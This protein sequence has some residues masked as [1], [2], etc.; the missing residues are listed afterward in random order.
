MQTATQSLVFDHPAFE[1]HEQV[2][3]CSDATTNLRAIIAIHSTTIGPALGGTR[4]WAYEDNTSALE[5]VLRLSKA[6]TYKNAL[7][8]TGFGGGKAVIIGNPYRDK[9]V[10]LIQAY[11]T[12]VA[13]LGGHFV[14][15]EDVGISMRDADVMAEHCNYVHGTSRSRSG[16]PSIYTVQGVFSGIEAAVNHRLGRTDLKGIRVSVQGLGNVGM[17]LCQLLSKA[18]AKLTVSDIRM[19]AVRDA[20][21]Q[22]GAEAI[23]PEQVHSVEVD[24]FVPCA[25]G[26]I[27]NSR[28]IPEIQARV[29]AGSANN[30][31]ETEKDGELLQRRGILYAP[32]YV[33]NAGGAISIAQDGDAFRPSQLRRSVRKISD[34]LTEIFERADQESLPTSLI[35]DRIAE[36]RIRGKRKEMAA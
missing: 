17:R 15:G 35:A 28:T 18:G 22:F 29:V 26:A 32:D 6:M 16:D 34:V 19:N 10:E 23:D 7:A 12:F 8:D 14:T 11:A 1:G 5:D 30:Q 33:I 9:T 3:F 13:R 27:L 20:I 2:I 21:T 36:E 31:L 4:M 24:V 25:L